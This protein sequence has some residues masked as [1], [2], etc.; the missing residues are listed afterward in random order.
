MRNL[1]AFLR[2]FQVFLLFVL[3]QV[4]ALYTYFS[5]LNF[6]RAQYLTSASRVNGAILSVRNDLTKHFALSENNTSLQNENVRLR[7]ELDAMKQKL[8]ELENAPVK[9]TDSVFNQQYTYLPATVINSTYTKA[10]NFFTLNVGSLQGI[11]RNMGVFSDKGILGVIHSVS[12][13]F[14]VVKSVLTENIN[15]DVMIEPA[16]LFGLLK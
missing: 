14:S 6:P 13:N 15:I 3:M 8:S 16:G 1:V 9:I 12:K 10:N 2:R 7:V 4:F 11:K 5:Y